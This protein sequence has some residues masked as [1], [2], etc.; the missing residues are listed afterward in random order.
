MESTT[1]RRVQLRRLASSA[2]ID[3]R[4][5]RRAMRGARPYTA[6]R[7]DFLA[8]AKESGGEFKLDRTYPCLTDRFDQGGVASG[9][10]FHQDLYVAQQ[11]HAAAPRRHV[12]VG[13]RVDGFVAH[14][15]SFR[16]VEVLDIRELR[17]T[18]RNITF[19]Q[20][21]ITQPDP[22]A[23]TSTDSLSC[24][25]A[26]EHVGL[27]R[28]GDEVDYYGYRKGWD[29]LTRMLEP[30]G[31]LY[32]SVPI[33]QRQRIEF[34]AHR[35]FSVRYLLDE[36]IAPAFDVKA[37]AY[38]DDRG[39]LH[40]DVDHETKRARRSFGLRYGCGIFTLTRRPT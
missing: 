2:G 7:R 34:D 39:D 16:P 5:L 15:A 26:L 6:N 4:R 9:Q 30:G 38:V 32:F 36:L 11:I 13:S 22:D 33:S 3:S 37:F 27:G 31:T 25:H 35:V 14:V 28:Y 40:T 24:L 23:D 18:A 8:Q 21:D 10:Y 1:G 29:S 19:R 17:T 12:D 20:R